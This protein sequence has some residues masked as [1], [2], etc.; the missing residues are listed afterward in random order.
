MPQTA[1]DK[2]RP[3]G[4]GLYLDLYDCDPEV[5]DNI[6]KCARFLEY[7]VKKLKMQKQSPP[8]IFR[9]PEDFPD[10]AGLSGWIPLIESGIQLHTLLPKRFASLDIYTCG[11]V[12]RDQLVKESIA[13]FK[14][15]KVEEQFL[16]RGIEYYQ[17]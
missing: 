17:H 2:P 13:F 5:L 8:Y 12:K 10:K 1:H 3:F 4:Y 11:E 16:L 9:S 7:L 14:A 15:S 6:D